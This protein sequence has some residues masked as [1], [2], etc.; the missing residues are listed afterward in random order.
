M[1][2]DVSG[3]VRGQELHRLRDIQRLPEP[4]QLYEDVYVSYP[5]GQLKRGANMEV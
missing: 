1:S 4:P 5:E 2:C 3:F